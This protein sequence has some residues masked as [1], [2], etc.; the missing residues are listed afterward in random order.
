M[1]FA[2]TRPP[3]DDGS[4]P[5][6]PMQPQPTLNTTMAGKDPRKK[7]ARYAKARL[8]VQMRPSDWATWTDDEKRRYRNAL[9][10]ERKAR[11]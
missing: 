5:L 2:D 10:R 7:S 4:A 8:T 9:K 3:V 1:R 11:R 6:R